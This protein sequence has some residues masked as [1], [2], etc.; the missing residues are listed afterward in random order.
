MRTCTDCDVAFQ[1]NILAD[2]SFGVNIELVASADVFASA[3]RV[4]RNQRH[5]HRC[6]GQTFMVVAEQD[7]HYNAFGETV[8]S[9]AIL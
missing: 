5:A 8:R 9:N 3:A 1:L 7:T 2:D 4:P 6:H